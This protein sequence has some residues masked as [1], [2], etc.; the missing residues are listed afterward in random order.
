MHCSTLY[1]VP[2]ITSYYTDKRNCYLCKLYVM[3]SSGTENVFYWFFSFV[4]TDDKD[5]NVLYNLPVNQTTVPNGSCGTVNQSI[6]IQ[7]GQNSQIMLQFTANDSAKQFALSEV[8]LAINASDVWADAKGKVHFDR[9][10][11]C[12]GCFHLAW[13][14]LCGRCYHY[15][16]PLVTE[17]QFMIPPCVVV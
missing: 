14:I 1:T 3:S 5:T 7:W 4:Q 17:I 8:H 16:Q 10:F 6:T 2:P 13:R 12:A 11:Y 15:L 9:L